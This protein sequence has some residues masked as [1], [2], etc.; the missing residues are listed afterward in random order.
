[1]SIGDADGPE[2]GRPGASASR[3]ELRVWY[4]ERLRPKLSRAIWEK[5]IN[6][7][8]AAAFDCAMRQLLDLHGKPAVESHLQES[9]AVTAPSSAPAP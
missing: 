2:R 1:V 8:R 5:D 9:E 4:F 7:A 3:A 6:P